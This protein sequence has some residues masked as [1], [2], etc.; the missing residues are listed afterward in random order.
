MKKYLPWILVLIPV[1]VFLQSLPF[2]FSGA[3]ETQYI[4][5]TIG[6]WMGSVGLS[7]AADPF[8]RYG[9]IGVGVAELIAS[10]LLLIPATRHWGALFGL[11]VL[12][13][14]IFFHVFTPLGIA[15]KYPGTE[16]SGDPTLF[17][18]AVVAWSCLLALVIRHRHRYP[19]IGS[20]QGS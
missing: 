1:A 15:V 8:A 18:M 16:P 2:K 4:F 3:V 20:R 11:G 13:G 12:S 14:A 19:I 7:F 5:T 17:V 6:A 9:A 10:V